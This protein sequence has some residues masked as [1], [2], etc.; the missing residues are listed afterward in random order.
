M[1]INLK[2]NSTNKYTNINIAIRGKKKKTIDGMQEK[3]PC[4]KMAGR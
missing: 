2:F 4:K 1:V 3:F